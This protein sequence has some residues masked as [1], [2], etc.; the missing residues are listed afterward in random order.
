MRSDAYREDLLSSEFRFEDTVVPV[1]PA[2]CVAKS[3]YVCDRPLEVSDKSI[4]SVFSA[5]DKVSCKSVYHNEFPAIC[6]GTRPL[7]MF[8]ALDIV[9]GVLVSKPSVPFVVRP[10]IYPRP[11]HFW[12]FA[13]VASSPVTWLVSVGRPGSS[14]VL[15]PPR[16][17]C[18][19][20]HSAKMPIKN[21]SQQNNSRHN[22]AHDARYQVVQTISNKRSDIRSWNTQKQQHGHIHDQKHSVYAL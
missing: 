13:G 18:H 8:T 5:Y 19:R 2:D 10:A 1:T 3:V 16:L 7:L 15:R 20:Q 14:L 9:F 17:Y 4:V 21:S 12:A 6:T 11:V 22:I